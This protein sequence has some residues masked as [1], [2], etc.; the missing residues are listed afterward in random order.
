RDVSVHD[1]SDTGSRRELARVTVTPETLTA[2]LL[3]GKV[4]FNNANDPRLSLNG[5][6]SCASCHL[7]G[8][9]DATTWPREEGSR[10]TMPLWGLA[11]TAPFHAAGTRDE[12]QDFEIDIERFMRGVWLAPGAAPELLGA[13]STGASRELDALAGF[14][15]GGFRIPVAPTVD[16]EAASRGRAVYDDRGCQT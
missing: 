4:L 11:G 8:G 2:D 14:L 5:W 3:R 10:Q 9:G 1:L 13:P 7:D 12:L 15:R 6:V 16:D